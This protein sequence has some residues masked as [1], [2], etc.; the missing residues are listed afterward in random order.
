MNTCIATEFPNVNRMEDSP[1]A[2]N[3]GIAIRV[4]P[5]NGNKDRL[6]VHGAFSVPVQDFG[7][8]GRPLHNMLVLVVTKGIQY[9]VTE[10]FADCVIFEDDEERS[11]TTRSGYFNLDLGAAA[12]FDSHGKDTY[13]LFSLGPFQS[14]IVTI[15]SNVPRG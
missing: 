4:V 15:N 11:S 10:P 7:R 9:V 6:L 1:K 2:D 14:N 13:V 12:D 8:V 5:L 3:P